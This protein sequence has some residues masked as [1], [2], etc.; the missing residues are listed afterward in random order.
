MWPRYGSSWRPCTVTV[1]DTLAEPGQLPVDSDSP[2]SAMKGAYFEISEGGRAVL[3]NPPQTINIKFLA[4]IGF[5][6]RQSATRTASSGEIRDFFGSLD[7]FKAN[8][9]CSSQRPPSRPRAARR[10]PR[11][12]ARTRPIA[13]R[14][15]APTGEAMGFSVPPRHTGSYAFPFDAFCRARS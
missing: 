12:R 2:S 4:W 8:K 6:S 3:A 5:T 1:D 7:R 13:V 10:H 11:R 9:G 15:R 14:P